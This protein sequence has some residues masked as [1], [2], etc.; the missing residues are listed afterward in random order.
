MPEDGAGLEQRGILGANDPSRRPAEDD[1][2]RRVVER[3]Q[4]PGDVA[5]RSALDAAL[6]ERPRR[7]ALEIDDHEI[8]ARVEHLAEVIVAVRPDAQT[9]D[10]VRQERPDALLQLR[11][12][13]QQL[14]RVGI[15]FRAAAEERERLHDLRPHRLI[16]RALIV[17]RERLRSERRDVVARRERE[18]HFRSTPPEELRTLDESRLVER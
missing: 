7:L 10:L 4:H 8:V 14:L 11:L 5:Q 3:P 6:A 15:L 17:L 1:R 13:F 9:A 12:V 16:D 2:I 18:M